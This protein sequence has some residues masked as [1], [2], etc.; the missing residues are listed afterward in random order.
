MTIVEPAKLAAE[1]DSDD[2]T[3]ARSSAV[4]ATPVGD[5]ETAP[6]AEEPV[7]VTA[8]GAVSCEGATEAGPWATPTDSD[9]DGPEV[10]AA[11]WACDGWSDSATAAAGAALSS[12][13]V[14]A[15]GAEEGTEVLAC[16]GAV[17][18]AATDAD[19]PCPSAFGAADV[20][21][22]AVTPSEDESLPESTAAWGGATAAVDCAFPSP[23][24]PSWEEVNPLPWLSLAAR[25][26]APEEAE[27]SP[28][29]PF[30]SSFGFGDAAWAEPGGALAGAEAAASAFASFPWPLPGVPSL[31][32]PLSDL[33]GPGPG[34]ACW[35][36]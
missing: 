20:A 2:G 33:T 8:A 1:G 31:P 18:D 26:A 29:F 19:S 6:G 15:P 13:T 22:S 36:F 7:G 30:A 17:D 23:S 21:T 5:A 28:E 3:P 35:V 27:S 25:A 24:P 11:A 34:V 14:E 32:L 4:K 16:G 9:D 12:P 10:V